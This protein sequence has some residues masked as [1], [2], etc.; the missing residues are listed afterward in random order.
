MRPVCRSSLKTSIARKAASAGRNGDT[1]AAHTVATDSP[2][3]SA[4]SSP[5][6]NA[7]ALAERNAPTAIAEE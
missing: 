7:T 5:N 4:A 2:P 1:A 3:P 6:E